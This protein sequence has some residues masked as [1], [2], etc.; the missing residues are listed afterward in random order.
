ML[1]DIFAFNGA[2]AWFDI[3]LS[4]TFSYREVFY[5]NYKVPINKQMIPYLL[6]LAS[7]IDLYLLIVVDFCI[8][9]G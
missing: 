5:S 1:I 4:N 7:K 2:T 9:I 6:L 8:I 3:I